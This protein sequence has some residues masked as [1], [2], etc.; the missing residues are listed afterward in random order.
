MAPRWMCAL[1]GASLVLLVG[2]GDTKDQ[3]PKLQ[4]PNQADSR[5]KAPS[6]PGGV[7]SKPSAQ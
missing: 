2:C 7:K 6:G 3:G 5:L 4:N 1:L